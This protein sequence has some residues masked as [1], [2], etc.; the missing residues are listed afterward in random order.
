MGIVNRRPLTRVSADARDTIPLTPAHFLSPAALISPVPSSDVL[1][2]EPLCGSALR[3]SKDTLRPLV[4]SLWKRWFNEY[5]AILQTRT[6]WI[7]RKRNLEKG[8]LVLIVDEL[9][10][11]ETWPLGLVTDTFPSEDGLVRRIRLKTAANKELERD[12]RKVVLL[13]REGE[14]ERVV[15]VVKDGGD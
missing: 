9:H 11:C 13:E 12:V 7:S 14:G 1:P 3:R 5:I 2:A 15:E 4:D 8:D 6:K 10:P